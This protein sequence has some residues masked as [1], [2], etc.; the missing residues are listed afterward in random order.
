MEEDLKILPTFVGATG[1][2]LRIQIRDADGNPYDFSGGGFTGTLSA[3]QSGVYK[4]Q[5]QDVTFEAGAD[6]WVWYLPTAGE[7][8]TPGDFFAQVR[9]V[10]GT[11]PDFTQR[12]I[13]RIK[14]P[15]HY[16]A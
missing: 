3:Q 13:L 10:T 16:T 1:R 7:V 14:D 2:K 15:D 11:G 4:I 5:A 9:F 8:D 6:G 12:F